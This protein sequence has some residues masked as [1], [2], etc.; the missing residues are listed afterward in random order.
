MVLQ[1]EITTVG[2][3]RIEGM[4]RRHD[5]LSIACTGQ[6]YEDRILDIFQVPDRATP[7]GYK[8]GDIG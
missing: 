4:V 8:F 3:I 7:L 6:Q 2:P 1:R 5:D